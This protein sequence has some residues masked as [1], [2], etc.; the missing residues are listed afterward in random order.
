MPKVSIII[1]VY[2]VEKYLRECLDSILAQT[3]EDIEIILIDDGGRDNC[4]QIIDEYAHKDKRI[5]A[6]HKPNG[7]YG[8]TCNYGIDRATGEYIAIVEPDD[9]IESNM[10]EDLYKLACKNDADIVKSGFYEDYDNP[11][12]YTVSK[13]L[14]SKYEIEEETP[15]QITNCPILLS[16]HPSI[17]SCIYNRKF[18]EDNNIRFIEARGAGWTDNPFQ[19]ATMCTAKKIVF[20]RNAYYHWRIT[21]YD[22]EDIIKDFHV[23]FERCFEIINWIKER[24]IN[25]KDIL[26]ALYLKY[27][28]YVDT[29]MRKKY[30]KTEFQEFIKLIEQ[31]AN[32]LDTE[33]INQSPILNKRNK[34][35]LMQL[36]KSAK[37]YYLKHKYRN[38][39]KDFLSFYKRQDTKI[40]KFLGREYGVKTNV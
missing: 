23:P 2:N 33:V 32:N 27:L 1:P 18:L 31:L 30:T 28:N 16:F 11:P 5:K 29:L 9:Y 36:K 15:F 20:T 17:W 3:L 19:I 34:Q 38:I 13:E 8:N 14:W 22:V 24:N 40:V 21:S 6:F 7:G 12:Q 25:D 26:G 10:Y 39:R 37:I 35:H 4:P